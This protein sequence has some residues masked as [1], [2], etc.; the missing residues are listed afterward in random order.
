METTQ[1]GAPCDPPTAFV[2]ARC[3]RD[4]AGCARPSPASP[5]ACQPACAGEGEGGDVSGWMVGALQR[6]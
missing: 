4:A 2:P 6:E 3:M 5:P 1:R